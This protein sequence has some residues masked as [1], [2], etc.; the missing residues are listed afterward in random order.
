[1]YMIDMFLYAFLQCIR[2]FQLNNSH[3][4][5]VLIHSCHVYFVS[6]KTKKSKNFP[7]FLLEY[8]CKIG[9]IPIISNNHLKSNIFIKIT[10]IKLNLNNND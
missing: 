9:I 1:M 5:M 7:T 8:G 2:Y 6:I 3:N 4:S 10:N